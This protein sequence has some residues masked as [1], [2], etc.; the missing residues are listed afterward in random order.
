M[1]NYRGQPREALD[2]WRRALADQP[3]DGET[4]TETARLLADLEGRPAAIAHIRAAIDQFPH[5]YRLRRLLIEWLYEESPSVHEKEVRELLARH[6][7]DAWAHRELAIVL[8]TQGRWEEASSSAETAHG[9]ESANPI[10][11][12]IRGR[13]LQGQGR[14]SEARLAMR[15]AIRHSVDYQHAIEGLMGLC[16]T[17][18]E[19]EEELRFVRGEL[20]RQVIFGDGL[21]MRLTPRG[22]RPRWRCSRK[23]W[24]PGPICGMPIRQSSVN[25]SQWTRP[26]PREPQD[27]RRFAASRCCR[28]FGSIWRRHSRVAA[29]RAARSTP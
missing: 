26:R 10:V 25:S 17:N 12:W 15:E 29:M 20:E 24:P 18:T 11:H 3:L 8:M 1:A 19:R 5:H 28:K 23:L 9:L 6:A 16:D 14:T 21:L 22:R 7:K 27:A 13:I 4:Q 2:C